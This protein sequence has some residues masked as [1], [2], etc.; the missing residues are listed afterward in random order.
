MGRTNL[1]M[2]VL[3]TLVT[4]QQLGGFAKAADRIGRTQ[5]AVSQQIRKLEAQVGQPLFRKQGR[6]LA[7]TEAGE[8]LLGYAQRMLALNDEAVGALRGLGPEGAIRLGLPTDLAEAW[9]PQWLARFGQEHPGTPIEVITDRNSQLLQAV[10]QGRLD[11]AIVLGPPGGRRAQRLASLPL[12][13]IGPSAGKTPEAGD[14]GLPLALMEAPC[15]YR[16]E[17]IAALDRAGIAWR[18]A[19]T[20]PSL[21]GLWP[22]VAAGLGLTVRTPLGLPASVRRLEPGRGLPAMPDIELSLHRGERRLQGALAKLDELIADSLS[23]T[24]ERCAA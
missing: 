7:L 16:R 15:L 5:S 19:F 18:P 8:L 11:V 6:G 3:R 14:G 23:P 20:T 9:L 13:W 2:D 21:Q 24:L 17:A 12:S 22:A 1:D 10:S 4:A